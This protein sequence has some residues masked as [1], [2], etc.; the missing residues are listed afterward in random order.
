MHHRS[1]VTYFTLLIPNDMLYK[2][3]SMQRK[4]KMEPP[5]AMPITTLSP[6]SLRYVG[7]SAPKR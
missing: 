5:T 7:F 2:P 3:F 1:E 4:P 6:G